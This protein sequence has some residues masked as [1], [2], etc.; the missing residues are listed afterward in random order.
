MQS[1]QNQ[2]LRQGSEDTSPG[3]VTSGAL[4][5]GE[6]AMV[7]GGG[8]WPNQTLSRV[9][10]VDMWSSNQAIWNSLPEILE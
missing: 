3:I 2:L 7:V 4:D 8:T 10:W 5:F 1:A 9:G 6:A